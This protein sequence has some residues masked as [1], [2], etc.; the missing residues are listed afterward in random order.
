[1]KDKL[2]N[3]RKHFSAQFKRLILLEYAKGRNPAEIF[4]DFSVDLTG[5]K[6]YAVKLINR[7]K[8]EVYKNMNILSLNF[9][10]IDFENA[11]Q[12]INSM[13]NDGETD[14]I[15]DELLTKNNKN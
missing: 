3:T 5:D 13:G 7:W 12:E 10:N 11:R 15:L 2:K 14:N 9:H 1:M 4:T 8:N 6:K